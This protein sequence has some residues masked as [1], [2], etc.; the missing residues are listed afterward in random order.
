MNFKDMKKNAT[1]VADSNSRHS[2]G[3][4]SLQIVNSESNGKRLK[5]SSALFKN[6]GEPTAVGVFLA[7]KSVCIY[8]DSEGITLSND[9]HNGTYIEPSKMT[10]SQSERGELS[11]TW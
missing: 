4:C 7:K 5:L 3:A 11:E 8:P 1:Y 2:A 6:L 9:I 10:V